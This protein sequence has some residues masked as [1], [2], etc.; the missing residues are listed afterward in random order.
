MS[1]WFFRTGKRQRCKEVEEKISHQGR[2]VESRSWIL[3]QFHRSWHQ[4]TCQNS[5]TTP[6]SCHGSGGVNVHKEKIAFK[7]NASTVPSPHVGLFT[8]P[9]LFDWLSVGRE[10]V[11]T[12]SN[13]YENPA[14]EGLY[15][16][17]LKVHEDACNGLWFFKI[18][19]GGMPPAP[20]PWGAWALPKLS[21]PVHKMTGVQK[22]PW[23]Y[24]LFPCAKKS[25]PQMFSV[26][27]SSCQR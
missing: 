7:F 20:P 22:Y 2:G 21:S 15:F 18:S 17:S 10:T 25:L 26:Q 5:D 4:Y 9:D 3:E 8:L 1:R 16:M 14:I 27:D 24:S 12:V 11:W 23:C 6:L 13:V 19:R